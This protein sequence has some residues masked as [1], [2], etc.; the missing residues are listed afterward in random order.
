MSIE[1]RVE[2]GVVSKKMTSSQ[3]EASLEIVADH[4]WDKG[5][6]S[7][8]TKKT[9]KTSGIELTSIKYFGFKISVSEMVRILLKRLEEKTEKVRM[10]AKTEEVVVSVFCYS[11]QNPDLFIDKDVVAHI[12]A[13][14]ASLNV[15]FYLIPAD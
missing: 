1:Y 13:L 7:K 8:L 5:S 3:L 2:F 15:D 12:A 10:L 4:K 14:G 6:V 11:N 9:M